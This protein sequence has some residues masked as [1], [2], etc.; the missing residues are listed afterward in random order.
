MKKDKFYTH[1]CSSC[2]YHGSTKF[3]NTNYDVYTCKSALEQRTLLL[4]FGNEGFE[5]MSSPLFCC[6]SFTTIDK[7]ALIGGLKL[8]STEENAL[9]RLF[10]RSFKN[11][12]SMND[13]VKYGVF[14]FGSEG[15]LENV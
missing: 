7:I 13:Y 6:S 2:E 11:D 14:D 8:T 1:D 9:F 4:R 3:E 12:M 10:L 5:Y 15:V